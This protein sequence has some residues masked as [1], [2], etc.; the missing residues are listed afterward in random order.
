MPIRALIFDLDNTLIADD[1]ANDAAFGEA[2]ALVSRHG[3]APDAFARA[4]RDYAGT[5]WR[6]G[7]AI[8]YARAIGIASWEGLAAS[9]EGDDPNLALLREWAPGYRRRVWTDTLAGFGIANDALADRLSDAYR[10]AR[11]RGHFAYDDTTSVLGA[12]SSD[13]RL[14]LLTNGAPDHQREK[15]AVAGLDGRFE[16]AIVSGELGIGKPDSRIFAHTLQ[17]LGVAASEAA[18]I[19]D[20]VERDIAGARACGIRAIRIDRPGVST[21]EGGDVTPD[22]VITTLAE[23]RRVLP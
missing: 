18:M 9:F 22:A 16:V 7:P 13:Y 20:S 19:G 5:L 14:A 23:L 11:R 2:C 3:I 6:A 12:L 10:E 15:I 4:V 21:S 1:E 17:A 8:D